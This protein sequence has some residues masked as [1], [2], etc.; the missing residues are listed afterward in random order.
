MLPIIPCL[1]VK[2]YFVMPSKSRSS[3][4]RVR[5]VLYLNYRETWPEAECSEVSGGGRRGDTEA[6]NSIRSGHRHARPKRARP[7]KMRLRSKAKKSHTTRG[8]GHVLE[9]MGLPSMDVKVATP[10]GRNTCISMAPHGITGLT[11]TKCTT[12][13]SMEFSM[14]VQDWQYRVVLTLS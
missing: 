4:D 3:S 9:Y 1:S 6:T 2:I 10:W 5:I 7:R 14:V 13:D 11:C 8:P 12:V